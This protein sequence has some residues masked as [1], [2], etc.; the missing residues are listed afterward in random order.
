M[1][2][3]DPDGRR[4]GPRILAWFEALCGNATYRRT[5]SA[6]APVAD[7]SNEQ[8]GSTFTAYMQGF[9]PRLVLPRRTPPSVPSAICRGS[10]ASQIISSSNPPSPPTW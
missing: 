2:K 3:G 7:C 5:L 1:P 6:F 10:N 4:G 9:H 8:N